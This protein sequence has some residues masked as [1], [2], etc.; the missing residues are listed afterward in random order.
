MSQNSEPGLWLQLE[1]CSL[2]QFDTADTSAR[3]SERGASIGRENPGKPEAP[4]GSR[5]YPGGVRY[6]DVYSP[7]ISTLYSQVC[8][9]LTL[10]LNPNPSPT[11]NPRPNP[12]PILT[13]LHPYPN[14]TLTMP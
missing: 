11:P 3:E 13:L 10:T 14:S 7:M 5:E 9:T 6:F 8:R 12:N 4:Q 1:L 2:P